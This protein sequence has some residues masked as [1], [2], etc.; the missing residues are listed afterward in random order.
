[1]VDFVTKKE[2]IHIPILV[3]KLPLSSF[4]IVTEGIDCFNLVIDTVIVTINYNIAVS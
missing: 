2:A 3:L 1:M 4:Y